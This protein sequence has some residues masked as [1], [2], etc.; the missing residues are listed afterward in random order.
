VPTEIG[1]RHARSQATTPVRFPSSLSIRAFGTRPEDRRPSDVRA[2]H[3]RVAGA[4]G[5]PGP[6]AAKTAVRRAT[7][8]LP[9]ALVEVV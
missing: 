9:R 7:E 6:G 5:K 1:G 2:A 8:A 3:E 4:S